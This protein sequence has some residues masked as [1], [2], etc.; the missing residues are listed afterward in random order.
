M[1]GPENLWPAR[2]MLGTPGLPYPHSIFNRE[3]YLSYVV[4][5]N[6]PYNTWR[7]QFER[8][9]VESQGP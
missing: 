6:F 8:G 9:I 2:E 5:D 3:D 1:I 4:R 7:I